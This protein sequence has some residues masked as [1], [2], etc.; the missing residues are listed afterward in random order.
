MAAMKFSVKYLVYGKCLKLEAII[1]DWL[2]NSSLPD[3]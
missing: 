1:K 3:P 2:K